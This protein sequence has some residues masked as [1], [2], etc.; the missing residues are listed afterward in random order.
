[1]RQ[2]LAQHRQTDADPG[3]DGAGHGGPDGEA[4]DEV[5]DAVTENDHPGD[6]RD[7]SLGRL[8]CLVLAGEARLMLVQLTV[9]A[10]HDGLHAVAVAVL[11]HHLLRPPRPGVHHDLQQPLDHEEQVDSSEDCQ[12]DVEVVVVG[13][14]LSTAA[15]FSA[16]PGIRQSRIARVLLS[17]LTPINITKCG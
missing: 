5:V 2:L 3:E 11:H 4:V 17:L 9:W 1:M 16:L 15:L 6:G 12:G 13:E 8:G 10:D 7:L 14:H